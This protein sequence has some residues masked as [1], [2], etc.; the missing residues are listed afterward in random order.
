[1]PIKP[2]QLQFDEGELEELAARYSYGKDEAAAR[3]AGEAATQ[4]GY[5][6]RYGVLAVVE[7]KS[8]RS[9]SSL[10]ANAAAV[11]DATGRA[12]ATVGDEGGRMDALTELDGVG[13]PI[14]SALLFF[15]YPVAYPI[16]DRRVVVSL[17]HRPR[18]RYPTPFWLR[19]LAFCRNLAQAREL[20]IRTVDKALWQHDKEQEEENC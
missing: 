17:G 7:W 18:G 9:K 13:V 16:L 14:A 10:E 8:E 5:Y 11:E 1:M 20:P 4:A 2:F 15:A 6:T 12:L 3:T 19:Y